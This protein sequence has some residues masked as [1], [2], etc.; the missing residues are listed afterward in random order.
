M[1]RLKPVIIEDL[2]LRYE[3]VSVE[4]LLK[5]FNMRDHVKE[6]FGQIMLRPAKQIHAAAMTL[7][8]FTSGISS[9]SSLISSSIST[10][11]Y[12][13]KS[14]LKNFLRGQQLDMKELEADNSD[15]VAK[16]C[17]LKCWKVPWSPT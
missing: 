3:N 5:L 10:S 11:L 14:L 17:S 15:V 8:G 12:V 16:L 4:M 13:I 1:G 6:I 9:D 7:L 2:E